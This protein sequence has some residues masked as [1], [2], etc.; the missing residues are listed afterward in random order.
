[1]LVSYR[2]LIELCPVDIDPGTAADRLTARGL[3]VDSV[4]R[5]RP[6][7]DAVLDVDVPA[8]RPDCLGHLGLARELA[9]ACGVEPTPPLEAVSESGE[10]L[11]G[12]FSVTVEDPGRC[13]RFTASLVRG[14]RVGP[15][16]EALV[17]RLE[18]CGLRSVNNVVDVSN[19]VLL[20]LG[21][22]IHFYDAATLRGGRMVVRPSRPDESLVTLDGESRALP[23]GTLVI[24]DADG[25]IG[26]AGVIGGAATEI[27]ETTRDVLIEAAW[28]EPSAV[29]RARRA[30]GLSTDASYRFERGCDPEAPVLAQTLARRWLA[31]YCEGIA[32]PGRVDERSGARAVPE[33]PLRGDRLR[34]LL[35]FDP[36]DEA[37]RRALVSVGLDV[38]AAGPDAWTVRPPSWRVD[39]TREADL[40][41]EV[42]RHL[43]YDRIPSSLPT[44]GG[45]PSAGTIHPLEEPAREILA[46]LGF[47]ETF[48]YAMI[49]DGEDA[50]F[51]EPCA[52]APLRLSNPIADTLTHLRRSL[53]PGL[54]ASVDRNLRRGS[55]DVRLFEVARAFRAGDE[56]SAFPGEPLRLGIAWTGAV[57]PPHWSGA[58]PDAEIADLAGLV[59]RVVAA[60]R[61]GAEPVRGDGPGL[62]GLHPGRSLA[63][64]DP[65][66]AWAGEIHPDLRAAM[67]L[68]RPVLL[69]EI[70]LD[71]VLAC[72]VPDTR[73]RPIPRVPGASRDLSLILAPGRSY[74]SLEERLRAVPA[75]ADAR[76]EV[77]D[78]Y[79]GEPLA[80]GEVSLTVRV[81]LQPL[82][83][84]LTDDEVESFRERLLEVV[85]SS[86]IAR[87]RS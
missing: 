26:I 38:A 82:E 51:V 37:I 61:P 24:A 7:G 25:P 57:R 14:V 50:P 39:L 17:R 79:V 18:A 76:F 9:A 4:D 70:D 42:A 44:V 71:R 84:T 33:I 16:P 74:G 58:V 3:T 40:V 43:G 22:P 15:S 62:G 60:I 2:W 78:R 55:R 20:G 53:L 83:R 52:P 28:F 23:E 34:R 49:A 1:M 68:S 32:A 65:P 80:R 66:L 72:A 36:G 21:Q 81:I 35:G 87:L 64:G 10:P 41:E 85:A 8:N 75:P 73:Y 69:A 45:E 54:L 59:E 5:D 48:H 67:D 86:E 13:G 29:R 63:W 6:D 27:R 46:H 47:H 30:L 77:V 11:P 56:P 12:S 19:L 31:E